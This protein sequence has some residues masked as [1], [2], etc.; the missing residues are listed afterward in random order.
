MDCASAPQYSDSF[1][2]GQEPQTLGP[3][4]Q[5]GCD[6]HLGT[7]GAAIQPH[8]FLDRLQFAFM[9]SKWNQTSYNSREYCLMKILKT[10]SSI[11]YFTIETVIDNLFYP[12]CSRYFRNELL[13]GLISSLLCLFLHSNFFYHSNH[14]LHTFLTKWN[15]KGSVGLFLDPAHVSLHN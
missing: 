5:W 12:L 7:M 9:Q 6:S 13:Y 11:F 14:S 4:L 10:F 1:A 8:T 3:H 15:I 2:P